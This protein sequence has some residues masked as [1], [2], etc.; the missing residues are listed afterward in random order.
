MIF[1]SYQRDFSPELLAGLGQAFLLSLLGF[2][3]A[4]A[5]AYLCLRRSGKYDVAVERFSVI[6]SNCGF[7]GIPLVMAMLGTE[8]VFYLTAVMTAFNLIVWTHGLF[9]FTGTGQFSIKGLL[10]A[11]CSPAILAVPVGLLCFLLQWRVPA[12]ALRRAGVRLQ[13]E[14]APGH[15]HRR[16]DGR[17]DNLLKAFARGR[18]YYVSFLKLLLVPA[19]IVLA[20]SLFPLPQIVLLTVAVAMASPT[21]TMGTI[22]AI[23]YDRN[24]VYA[25][26]LFAV[27]TILSAVSL[28]LVVFLAERL[29]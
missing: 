28:P 6:Y 12:G 23:R 21:A 2:G 9:L 8:G 25:S 7:M 24:A 15:A 22:F 18:I 27:T 29:L 1:V 16:G 11:L 14:H 13:H 10:R 19:L 26:E 20:L 3:I 4:M 17:A 5:V